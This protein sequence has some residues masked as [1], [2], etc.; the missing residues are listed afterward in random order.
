MKL[1][2]KTLF[3]LLLLLGV[4]SMSISFTFSKYVYNKLWTQYLIAS[5]LHLSSDHLSSKGIDNYYNYWF[6]NDIYFNIKNYINND[7]T[8]SDIVYNITCEI[9][10]DASNYAECIINNES[11]SITNESLNKEEFC[12]NKIDEVDVSLYTKSRCDQEG[13]IWESKKIKEELFFNVFLTN[14]NYELD[15]VEVLIKV[16]STSP[17]NKILKGTFYLKKVDQDLEQLTM[18]ISHKDNHDEL[19]II[20]TFDEDRCYSLNWDKE[21]IKLLEDLNNFLDYDID[22]T[23]FVNEVHFKIEKKSSTIIRF[24]NKTKE[25]DIITDDFTTTELNT[26]L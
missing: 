1:K 13:Y 16:E 18:D 8:D 4:V 9:E 5:E 25:I 23:G 2:R 14:E 19:Y 24:Y 22:P 17:Y 11:S 26:C 7:I 10:G 20:N 3:M 15:E 12:I 21:N 6:G